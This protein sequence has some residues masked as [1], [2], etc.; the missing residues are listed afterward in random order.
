MTRFICQELLYEF[1]TGNL[2]LDRQKAL[3][4]HLT[5]CRESQRELE[6]LKAGFRFTASM[7]KVS[8]SEELCAAL[9]SFEPMWKKR[10][11]AGTQWWSRHGWRA[12]PYVIVGAVIVLTVLVMKPWTAV[13]QKEVTLVENVKQEVAMTPP[14]D[15]VKVETT[16]VTPLLPAKS[17]DEDAVR[18][19]LFR[20]EIQVRDFNDAWPKVKERIIAL[21][22]MPAGQEELGEESEKGISYF[23]FSLPES[24]QKELEMYLKTFG[25][26]QF[27]QEPHPRVMPE[28]EIHIILTIK[29][30][31]I[32][33]SGEKTEAP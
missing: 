17:E 28:G 23:H 10:L 4:A 26:V 27:K 1:A 33:E 31:T 11:R 20:A 32:T 22:G 18:A 24:N 15:D 29:D 30:G 5:G 19:I 9:L 16:G 8:V 12:L 14:P 25:P 7:A 3:D 13:N 2:D 21:G 6:K